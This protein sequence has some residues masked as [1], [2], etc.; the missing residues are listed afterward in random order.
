[1]QKSDGFGVP[2]AAEMSQPFVLPWAAV[3]FLPVSVTIIHATFVPGAGSIVASRRVANEVAGSSQIYCP[4]PLETAIL[5][6][7]LLVTLNS[8]AAKAG[9][10]IKAA[11]ATPRITIKWND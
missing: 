5:W 3:H 1:M 4:L 10:E 2:P 6:S 9:R 7:V 11:A 8:V